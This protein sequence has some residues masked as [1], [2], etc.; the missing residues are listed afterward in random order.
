[1]KFRLS[2]KLSIAFGSLFAVVL[3]F[4]GVTVYTT[5]KAEITDTLNT[6]LETTADLIKRIVEAGIDNNWG[7]LSKNRLL[8]SHLAGERVSVDRGESVTYRTYNETRQAYGTLDLPVLRIDGERV[9]KREA[10]VQRIAR[11]TGGVVSVYQK[12]EKGFVS[13]ASTMGYE[14]ARRGVGHLIPAGGPMHTLITRDR[15]YTG[16]DYFR[17][18]WYLVAYT[19]LRRDG[20]VVGA[21]FVAIKQVDLAAL[22][23][24]I[25]SIKVGNRG[26][27]YIIDSV[28]NVVIHP[29]LEGRNLFY[30]PH[31]RDIAFERSGRAR[32][33]K[34]TESGTEQYVAVY[35]SIPAMNWIV[36]ASAPRDDFF[37]TLDIVQTVMF[38]IFG[39]A[40]LAS[41]VLSVVLGR[42]VTKPVTVITQK[43]KGISEGEADLSSKLDVD[44]NDEIG[45]LSYYFNTFVSKVRN[46]K[47]VERREIEVQLRDAQMNALQAQ[48]NP[49]FLYNT[50]ETVRFMIATKDDRAVRIVQNL[51]DLFRISIGKGERYV[52]LK[53][54]LEH[55]RLYVSI[56]EMRYPD[57]FAVRIHA[58]PR[59]G[60]LYILKF[61]LQPLVENAVHHGLS[62]VERGGLVEIVARVEEAGEE[63]EAEDGEGG[64]DGE[65]AQGQ[66]RE[67]LKISVRDNGCGMDSERLSA[68]RQQLSGTSRTRSV[69]LANVNERV[70]LH[71]GEP[72][73]LRLSSSPNAGTTAELS[74]PVMRQAPSNVVVS[75]TGVRKRNPASVSRLD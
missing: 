11:Q 39:L 5:V 46:L 25:L 65:H 14:A 40:L 57:R 9:S 22:R 38:L 18:S 17:S 20:E 63:A 43:I 15:T 53:R 26:F 73:G 16:R 74:L 44:S 1:M 36:M 27:P 29:T 41:L 13:V 58:D 66:A 7:Q 75:I 45:E 4:S 59:I 12:S 3:A 33:P 6:H 52:Q 72:Y 61:V 64:G 69:G 8:A 47:E 50:L 56:Q 68:V 71:F 28:A 51:A 34:E 70:R 32:F 54:E 37:G 21:L 48:I 19:D 42:R 67:M 31:M 55:V 35:K 30:L 49:H 62:G 60:E 2:H 23:E 10:L 24:D